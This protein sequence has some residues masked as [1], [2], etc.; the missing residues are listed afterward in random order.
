MSEPEHVDS[1][2]EVLLRGGTKP[3]NLNNFSKGR[4][5]GAMEKYSLDYQNLE[6]ECIRLRKYLFGLTA[7]VVAG[8]LI[9]VVTISVLFGKLSHDLVHHSHQPKVGEQI[10]KILETEELCVPCDSVRLGPSEDED[11]MLDA[12]IRRSKPT[13]E[14]CCVEKPKQLLAVLELFIEKRLRE[15]MAR[16]TIRP[17]HQSTHSKN[18]TYAAHLMGYNRRNEQPGVPGNQF[19]IPKWIHREDLAFTNGVD[20][21]NGRL[22]VPED[23][24]FYVY[25]HVSFA[26]NFGHSSSL[27]ARSN[28]NSL[29]HYLYRYNII[30]RNGGEELLLMNSLTKCWDENKQFGEYS[31]YL[32]ALFKLRRG[33]E[34]FVKV[35]NLTIIATNHK[36]NTFGFFRVG[37]FL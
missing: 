9:L 4:S 13:G 16:G 28:S 11:R 8:G 33:D 35:S 34:L 31:S 27:D 2:S 36:I 1:S 29:S 30:Y 17:A 5:T 6:M 32:G 19:S 14:E 26:E 22:V 25:S 18:V 15:E 10:A 7:V 23:G 37:D 12:F 24:L 21:R 3:N 20:Y